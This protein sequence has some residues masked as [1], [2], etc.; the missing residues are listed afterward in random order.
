MG[1]GRGGK[2][3]SLK[4]S[5]HQA[6]IMVLFSPSLPCHPDIARPAPQVSL[7]HTHTD[8]FTHPPSPLALQE[9]VLQLN[10]ERFLVPEVLFSPTDIG[11][12]QAGVPEAVV[13]AVNATHAALQPL[14]YTNVILTGKPLHSKNPV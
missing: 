2:C 8:P 3:C 6:L 9:Q 11:L 14:L 13:Q 10:N 12:N 1:S 5:I 7:P 4:T